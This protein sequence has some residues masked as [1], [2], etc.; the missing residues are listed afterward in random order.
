MEVD[1][2]APHGAAGEDATAREHPGEAADAAR[3]ALK[4]E[5]PGTAGCAVENGAALHSLATAG[6][7][8]EGGPALQGAART[9]TGDGMDVGVSRC[10]TPAQLG[11]A[12]AMQQNAAAQSAQATAARV[13]ESE[14]LCG[15]EAEWHG[16]AQLEDAGSAGL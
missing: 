1:G 9:A 4:D 2:P 11:V 8:E 13:A 16:A 12:A 14:K 6:R 10:D 3:G 7:A 15:P 5:E